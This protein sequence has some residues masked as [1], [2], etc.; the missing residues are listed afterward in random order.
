MLMR[1]YTRIQVWQADLRD[2][3]LAEHGATAVEYA[4]MLAFIFV[5]IFSAVA[6]LGQGTSTSF[7]SVTFTPP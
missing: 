4:L 2:R 7:S 5:V 6:F 3:L 1:V